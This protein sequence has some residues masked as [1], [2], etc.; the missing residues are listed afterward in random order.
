M[1]LSVV[2]A[3]AFGA[4]G[5]PTKAVPP[6]EYAQSICTASRDW[7]LQITESRT[8][9]DQAV[10]GAPDVATKKELTVDFVED[11]I[12]TT[13]SLVRQTGKAGTPNAR[14]GKSVAK[15]YA[16]GYKD[17]REDF[18]DVLEDVQDLPTSDRARFDA[19]LSE[20]DAT[21]SDATDEVGGTIEDA[22]D[23]FSR[24]LRAAFGDTPACLE[25]H[26]VIPTASTANAFELEDFTVV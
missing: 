5:L 26:A 19:E 12:E 14:R 20:V 1:V 4:A 13:R 15:I 18:D 9:Y 8:V 16:S 23:E 17:V 3:L 6:S 11:A 2:V 21:L 10:A 7:A 25:V 22:S 24:E